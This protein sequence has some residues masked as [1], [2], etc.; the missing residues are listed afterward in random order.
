MK[1]AAGPPAT[2]NKPKSRSKNKIGVSHHFFRVS[3]YRQSSF[4]ESM[5]F[6]VY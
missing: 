4:K 5:S 2:T 1:D 6:K 3:M